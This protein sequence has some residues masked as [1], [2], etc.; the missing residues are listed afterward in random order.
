MSTGV[1]QSFAALAQQHDHFNMAT[2]IA[3]LPEHIDIALERP[4]A[5][6]SG[7]RRSREIGVVRSRRVGASIRSADGCL[8]RTSSTAPMRVLAARTGCR[9][10]VD[11][12]TLLI[13]SSFSGNTEETLS[14]IEGIA[15]DARNVVVI[16]AGGRLEE[17]ARERQYPLI[18]IPTKDEPQGFQPRSA[19]GFIVTYLARVLH[20]AG[21]MKD[22][23]PRLREARDFLR[24][25][26]TCNGEAADLA[27]WLDDRIPVIYTD[28]AHMM[29]VARITK[30]KFNENAKRPAFFNAFPEL[31]HNE[32]I[33]F[34]EPL[35]K[36]GVLYLH[37]PES[38]PRIHQR[39][40][41]MQDVFAREQI[42]Q[43]RVSL[44]DDARVVQNRT[45]VCGPHVRRPL[46]VLHGAPGGARSHTGP[47]GREFQ[48]PAR[49]SGRGKA[50]VGVTSAG[51]R[52]II[53]SG[54]MQRAG[55]CLT[56][57]ALV[58]VVVWSAGC[59]R[60]R[61]APPAARRRAPRRP[62]LAAISPA[63]SSR[64]RIVFLGDSLTAGYGLRA[65]A[66]GAVA[67]SGAPR[68]GGLSASKSSTRAS[69]ATRR[70]A[71]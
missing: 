13:V 48:A 18:V 55:Q 25:R 37:D 19:F 27:S 69:R 63:A 22:P 5:G 40:E 33:G 4:A 2:V 8:C 26:S 29:S 52:T 30:I 31:N 21:L 64:P 50:T 35:G 17:L 67:H 34:R 70:P 28:D 6:A 65:A 54:A 44:V 3:R 16:T 39:F 24:E 10:R 47:A 15:P 58:A 38:H 59:G 12:H 43:R 68:R 62:R 1:P 46:L 53:R 61:A 66:V 23:A 60:E 56:A 20:G 42:A 11:A 71:A 7:R 9:R 32:M 45:R 41:V 57:C 51:S 49:R 36:F 14:G